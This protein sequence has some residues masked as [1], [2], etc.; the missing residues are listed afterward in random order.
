MRDTKYA[1]E[2]CDPGI[3][4]FPSGNE[5][6]IEKLRIKETGEEEIRFS[7]WK[8]EKMVPRPLDISE[9]DLVSLFRN[10]LENIVFSGDFRSKLRSLL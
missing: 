8:G 2:L 5:A 7:W 4:R 10:A 6:R 3:F 9:S 1:T